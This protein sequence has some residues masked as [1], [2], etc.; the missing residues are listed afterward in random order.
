MVAAAIRRALG[1]PNPVFFGGQGWSLAIVVVAFHRELGEPKL[2]VGRR[3]RRAR[4][5]SGHRHGSCRRRASPGARIA[6]AAWSGSSRSR[7]TQTPSP[8]PAACINAPLT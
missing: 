6:G 7:C 5:T 2:E 1:H 8:S 4:S 3:G